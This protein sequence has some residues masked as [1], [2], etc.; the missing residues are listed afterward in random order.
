MESNE[1]KEYSKR[2]KGVAANTHRIRVIDGELP[3][4]N[5]KIE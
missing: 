5:S 2:K 3:Q 4:I 1:K